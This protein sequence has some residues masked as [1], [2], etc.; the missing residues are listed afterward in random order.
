MF[1]AVA[2]AGLFLLFLLWEQRVRLRARTHAWI[3]RLVLNLIVAALAFVTAALLIRP[4]VTPLVEGVEP[5]SMGLL[6]IVSFP[7]DLEFVLGFL[8]MDLSFYYWHVA[9][10]RM[11]FLWRF[12]NVHHVDPDLDVS[13]AVRFHFGEVGLSAAFR[14]FQVAIIGVNGWMY[15]TYEMAFQ[16]NTLFHH[17]NVKLPIVIERALNWVL[18]TPRMHGIHHSQVRDETNSNYSVVFSW[19]DRLHGSIGLDIPQSR[20][21][22]GV[23]GY[24]QPED[25]R[26]P[27][28]FTMPFQRQRPYWYDSADPAAAIQSRST[29][30]TRHRLAE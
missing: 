6:Q 21:A 1:T 19:W 17:S 25:N 16:A 4:A 10:H 28:V 30:A 2:F 13:T 18:V 20:L 9:N 15:V 24:S 27:N 7:P 22:I 8:L 26:F 11:P 5:R 29:K 23:P 12:H 3:P 14:V